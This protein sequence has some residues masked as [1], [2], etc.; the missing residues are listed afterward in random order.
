MLGVIIGVCSVIIMVAIVQGLRQKIID[1]FMS[2]GSNIIFA[3]YSPKPGSILRGGYQGLHMSDIEAIQR[4]C[5][6]IGPLSP[7][8][9]TQVTAVV[10]NEVKSAQLQGV[11]AVYPN[12]QKISVA[13][14]RFIDEHDDATFSKACVIGTKTKTDLFGKADPIGKEIICSVGGQITLLEVVG[15]LDEKDQQPGSPDYNNAIFASLRTVQ[16]RFTGSD[17]IDGFS[18]RSLDVTG[19]QHAADEVWAVLK[20]THPLNY[21]DFIVDTQE[22]LLKQLDVIIST[23]QIVLGG[24]GGLA[25]L[26]GGIGIMNIMLVSVTERTREIGIRK[27][28]GATRPAILTQFLVEAMVVSGLGGLIG[29]AWGWSISWLVDAFAHK[30]LPTYV[31]FWA[32][33]LGFSFAVGVGLFFGIFPAYRASKLDPIQALRYE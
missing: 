13:E 23:L 24:V 22:G 26:T 18:T 7:S 19:T 27:A 5:T 1:Q 21:S 10:G 6:L 16:Q 20:Q 9:S 3:F 17:Q 33:L 15:V 25:L 12:T 2:N 31:P 28:V 30:I 32:V 4:R 8:A 11:L 29:I 14:G